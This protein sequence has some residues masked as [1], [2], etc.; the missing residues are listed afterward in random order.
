MSNLSESEK[1]ELRLAQLARSKADKNALTDRYLNA[2]D[3]HKLAAK[4]LKKAQGEYN[5][6]SSELDQ[7]GIKLAKLLGKG[8]GYCHPSVVFFSDQNGRCLELCRPL[9]V[10]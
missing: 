2:R 8:Y 3:R 10:E 7:L 1:R 9:V 4:S 6:A 5:S